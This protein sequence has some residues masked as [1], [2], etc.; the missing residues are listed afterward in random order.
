MTQ[1]NRRPVADTLDAADPEELSVPQ[2]HWSRSVTSI[3]AAVPRYAVTVLE[4]IRRRPSAAAT[5]AI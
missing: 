2:A 1:R 3:G 4:A 5:T